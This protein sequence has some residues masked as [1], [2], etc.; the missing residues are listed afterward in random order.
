MIRNFSSSQRFLWRWKPWGICSRID[1]WIH[2]DVSEK[3]LVPSSSCKYTNNIT[4]N[5][6]DEEKKLFQM[7]AILQWLIWHYIIESFNICTFVK[8][9][10][11]FYCF[12]QLKLPTNHVPCTLILYENKL[13]G[14]TVHQQY[15]TL[16]I[17]NWCT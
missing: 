6:E 11:I 3:K 9:M 5:H 1:W 15:W 14:Y 13:H 10:W 7:S 17:T 16:F 4:V 8:F 2:P 12:E